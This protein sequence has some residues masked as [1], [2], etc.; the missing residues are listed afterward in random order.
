[1]T[2]VPS[3]VQM[4]SQL[5]GSPSIS[6][7]QASWD[8]SNKGV[9]QLLESW[10]SSMG[11]ECKVLPLPNQPEKFNLI[12]T[13]GKGNGG[14]VLSGHTDTVPYDEGRWESDPFKLTE[15]DQKLYGL[16]ACD[17]KGF[18]AI[19]IDT[20]RDMDLSNLAE[21]LIILATADEESSMAGARALS[22]QAKWNARYALIGEPTSLTP[23]HAHKG[24]MMDKI[25]VTGQAGHSSNPNLGRSAMDAM[26]EVMTELMSFR[27]ELKQTYRDASFVIDYPTLNLGCIHGG[28]NP[29]RICG[30]CEIEFD[31]RA[32]PGMSNDALFNAVKQR[33]PTIAERTNTEIE[34]SSLFPDVPSFSTPKESDII[35]ACEELTNND[36]ETVAF[37]TEGPFLNT[38][39]METLVLGPGSIDQAHQPNEFLALDQLDPM[40][41][42]IKGLVERFCTQRQ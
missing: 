37:A 31:M 1:M 17:M 12:A 8:Q 21:P 22:Q 15:R 24:I 38:L 25:R 26:H 36:A 5:I 3:L 11:F 10:L 4:M 20:L 14:L 39:G 29:N 9:I 2:K 40:Q 30:K 16:G 35:K 13:I 34:L 33:L 6:C 7:S 42:V 23:I 18:F 19:V 32:L 28:D 41:K 27:N